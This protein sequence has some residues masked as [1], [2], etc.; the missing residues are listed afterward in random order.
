MSK[1][2]T[3]TSRWRGSRHLR[4]SRRACWLAAVIAPAVSGRMRIES[5]NGLQR[6]AADTIGRTDHVLPGVT[7]S[8]QGN[9]R[10]KLVD[11]CTAT[12][13][14]DLA[15]GLGVPNWSVLRSELPAPA[16]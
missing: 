7:S 9:N 2:L 15:S 16:N 8:D 12:R 6:L 11:R 1:Q 10:I 4:G 13:G 3:L 14:Y 5:S